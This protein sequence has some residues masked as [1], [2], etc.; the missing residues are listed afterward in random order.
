MRA[1]AISLLILGIVLPTEAAAR[2]RSVRKTTL[3]RAKV[4]AEVVGPNDPGPAA[5]SCNTSRTT[6]DAAKYCFPGT[7]SACVQAG[8]A[9]G[10]AWRACIYATQYG[11]GTSGPSKGFAI[12]PVDF[13]KEAEAPWQ[14]VIYTAG[15]A[16]IFTGYDDVPSNQNSTRL[17]DTRISTWRNVNGVTQ[18]NW[19]R[20]PLTP[21]HVPAATGQLITLSRDQ[22]FGPRVAGECRD[23][24]IA[25][26]CHGQDRFG[27]TP[28]ATKVRRSEELVLWGVFDAGNY[29]F[30]IEYGFRDDGSIS[31]RT[32]AT[33]YN[34]PRLCTN[35]PGGCGAVPHIHDVLWRVDVD[36]N[37]G[38][39]DSILEMAHKDGGPQTDEEGPFN[40]GVEG[41]IRWNPDELTSLAIEDVSR[42]NRFGHHPG[43]GVHPMRFGNARQSIVTASTSEKEWT[44]YDFWATRWHPEENTAWADRYTFPDKYLNDYTTKPAPEG[45]Q[46]TDVVLWYMTTAHHAPIDE[47]R[48]PDGDYGITLAH[49]FGFEMT[50][51]N[52]FEANPVGRPV[53]CER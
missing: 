19:S 38:S 27:G 25:W 29:D 47:D 13:R 30:V 36:V 1:L 41:G 16:E 2:R 46:D 7:N 34:N 31:F 49:F 42:V 40:S 8:F 9:D 15:T 32:G 51:H 20:N 12:G 33:G 18:H 14:R 22:S 6:C 21:E 17:Y 43:Y 39:R 3:D 45:L 28:V 53:V 48:E 10:Q 26:L 5:G 24:G 35:E 11:T 4:M 37:G 44:K 23:R 52:Y 50:P